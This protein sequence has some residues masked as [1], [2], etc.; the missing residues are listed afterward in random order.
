M[1]EN[2]VELIV[3]DYLFGNRADHIV[4]TLLKNYSRS[5]VKQWIE[6]GFVLVNEKTIIP[7]QKLF[8]GEKIIV[9]IQKDDRD[10]QFK[11]DN[12][13]LEIIYS[14]DDI[15]VLNKP[16]GLVVHPADGNWTGTLLNRI[17]YHFPENKSL[18]R[19]GI[20]H[21]LDKDTSGLLVIALNESSQ[22]K[23]IQQ[24]QEKRVYREYR[25]IVW[26]NLN[27]SGSINEPIGRH[28]KNRVKMSV[29]KINGKAAITNYEP[30]ENFQYHTYVKCILETGRTHQIR[31]HM[32]HIGKPIVGDPTYG[33]KKI[34]PF[35]NFP[36]NFIDIIANFPR[37]ALHAKKLGLNHPRT[38]KEMSW[39]IKLPDDFSCLLGH[40][41]D[42][43]IDS[44]D[45]VFNK[46]PK[47]N[48]DLPDI[49]VFEDFEQDDN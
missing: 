38:N 35:K 5:R 46:L 23:L 21:R 31:V 4:S 8:T 32:Q 27:L 18:P 14:D 20:V 19:A 26:G 40:I 17:L 22:L 49:E 1:T 29:N 11:P 16:S 13:E 9:F 48:E 30:I 7:K 25:A 2:K 15:A 12:L 36:I 45:T 3:P 39:E 28:P 24:L 47:V 33:Y 34:L 42:I 44:R 43:K 37:Q 6:K 10:L 41:R